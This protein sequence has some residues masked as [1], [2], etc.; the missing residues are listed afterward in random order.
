MHI[1]YRD[2]KLTSLLKHSLGGNS[3]TLMVACLH[4]SDVFVEENISTLMYASKASYISNEPKR[5]DDPKSKKLIV[6]KSRMTQLEEELRAANEQIQ[7]L[8]AL[9]ERED[10]T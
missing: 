1:P 10:R 8:S 9:N 2:S 6:M 4:P 3:Y 7:I 5:N